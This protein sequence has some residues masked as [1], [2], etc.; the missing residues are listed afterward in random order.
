[1]VIVA[2]AT[3]YIEPETTTEKVPPFTR[4]VLPEDSIT[5]KICES[6]WSSLRHDSEVACKSN[7]RFV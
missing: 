6:V 4:Q 5:E 3:V 2:T 1:M 7:Q